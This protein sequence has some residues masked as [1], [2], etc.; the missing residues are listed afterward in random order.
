MQIRDAIDVACT[1]MSNVALDVRIVCYAPPVDA[2]RD[3]TFFLF[4]NFEY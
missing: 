3:S 1:E 2:V 4:D